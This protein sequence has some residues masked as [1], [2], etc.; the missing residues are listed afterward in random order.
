MSLSRIGLR[1]LPGRG[2][3]LRRRRAGHH[4][5]QRQGLHREPCAAVGAG[6]RDSRRAHRRR[7][8]HRRRSP[9]WPVRRRAAS[10]WAAARSFPASTTRTQHVWHRAAVRSA[11]AAVRSD[12]RSDRRCA[13]GADQDV[14]GRAADRGRVRRRRPG[15]IRRSRARGSIAIAPDHPV[16]LAAFTGHGTLLN[17][18]ALALDRHRRH[19]CKDPEGGEFGRDARGPARTGASRNT[20]T[21]SRGGACCSED[22]AGRDR[23]AVYRQFAARGA[24][25]RHHQHAAA[26]RYLP[27]RRRLEGAGRRR[28]RRC[29]G[30]YFRFPMRDGRRRDAS[31]AGRRCRR[32]RRRSS[33]C[34]A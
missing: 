28:T 3:R 14:A 20:R 4:P 6:D 25:V 10:M 16:W 18:R 17:S 27:V 22:R 2:R 24:R 7:R 15:T 33:T 12:H 19:R 21:T 13:R 32:S 30:E 5:H 9:R 11:D 1:D 29:A 8:R 34:A 31:T 23:R 26:R